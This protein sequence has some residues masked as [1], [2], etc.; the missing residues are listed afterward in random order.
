MLLI[1][2]LRKKTSSLDR[3]DR[4]IRKKQL[5]HRALPFSIVPLRGC[6]RFNHDRLR[7]YE[8]D[9][10]SCQCSIDLTDETQALYQR[11]FDA[12]QVELIK[13]HQIELERLALLKQLLH[14]GNSHD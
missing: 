13:Q 7:F 3:L 9:D 8:N 1:K 2:K 5:S 4:K 10:G 12:V 11:Y 14:E 6:I